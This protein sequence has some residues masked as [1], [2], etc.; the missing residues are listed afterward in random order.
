M[1]TL[2]R[3]IKNQRAYVREKKKQPLT[4]FSNSKGDQATWDDIAVTF[5]YSWGTKINFLF[6]NLN[7]PN[8][9]IKSTFTQADRLDIEA[10]HLI[11]AYTLD[12]LSENI[13][14]NNKRGKVTAS[15][16]FISALSDNVASTSLD[17]IQRVIYNIKNPS[18]L[19]SFFNWLRKY[20][21]LPVSCTPVIP[22]VVKSTRTM[23][24]DDALNAEK[25]KIPDEKALIALG[26]IFN[27]VIPQYTNEDRQTFT[28]LALHHRDSFTCTMAALA[29]ASPNRVTAEQTLLT[30]QRIKYRI[31]KVDKK[32]ETV[33]YLNWCGSKG[34]KDY[35]NHI[36]TEMATSL[37]RALHYT[38]IVTEPARVICSS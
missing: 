17:E 16:Q 1:N 22:T 13:S 25:S 7:Q 36:N 6:N 4:G 33:H 19:Y 29:M 30:K 32:N 15:R 18:P 14:D 21:M 23:N 28:N 24:C 35:Q 38:A 27:D 20:K 34:F 5:T 12:V 11:F 37:D 26:A 3:Y 9:S 31:E 10:H 8:A 2:N